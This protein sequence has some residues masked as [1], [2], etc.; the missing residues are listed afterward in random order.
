MRNTTERLR[1]IQE[2][3]ANI[4]KYTDQG[5][6]VFDENEL[7]QTWVIRHLEIIGEA[8]S[9]IPQDFRKRYP[10]VSWKQANGVRN[11]LIH[12]YFKVDHD[13]IWAIVEHD[14]PSLK[15]NIDAILTNEE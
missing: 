12:L 2:A 11:I 3:I 8:V 5:R 10:E 1:D 13:T 14:L 15:T 6:E 9:A 4:Q 7:I